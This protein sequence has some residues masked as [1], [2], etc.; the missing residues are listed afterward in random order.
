MEH[1]KIFN[2]FFQL[3][4]VAFFF[5]F[6]ETRTG[7]TNYVDNEDPQSP[8][9][10]NTGHHVNDPRNPRYIADYNNE[11]PR[12]PGYITNGD[13]GAPRDRD[14][15]YTAD[16]DNG[17]PRN[18]KFMADHKIEVPRS[19]VYDTGFNNEGLRSPKYNAGYDM[20]DPRSSRYMAGHHNKAFYDGTELRPIPGGQNM[21][22]IDNRGLF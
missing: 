17:Y 2:L 13:I 3:I 4:Y 14:P 1:N 7:S 21:A 20:K 16:H 12:S 9:Y 11:N 19:P 8:T 6:P 22:A 18:P 15:K 5:F 10:A